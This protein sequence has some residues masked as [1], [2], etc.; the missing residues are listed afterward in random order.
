MMPAATAVSTAIKS[1]PV[2]PAT[3]KTAV[4]RT[5]SVMMMMR[6]M[7]TMLPPH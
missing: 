1:A 4:M 7:L 2:M 3:A 6:M 5:G